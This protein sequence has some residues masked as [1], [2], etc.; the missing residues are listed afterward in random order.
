MPTNQDV[1]EAYR[2][3][4]SKRGTGCAAL[5]LA[6]GKVQGFHSV[7]LAI[8]FCGMLRDGRSEGQQRGVSAGQ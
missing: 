3:I 4:G 5:V 6:D 8:K 1:L 2:E 7:E